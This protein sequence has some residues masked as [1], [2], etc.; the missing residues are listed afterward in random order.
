MSQ[1]P[2]SFEYNT[3]LLAFVAVAYQSNT[4]GTFLT[5]NV[6]ETTELQLESKTISVWTD[7]LEHKEMYLNHFYSK[8]GPKVL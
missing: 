1:F 8:E 5:N 4:Y 2:L 7:V 6:K 3:R